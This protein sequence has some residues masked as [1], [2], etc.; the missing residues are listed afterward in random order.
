MLLYWTLANLACIKQSSQ[1][2]NFL[3]PCL[4]SGAGGD[5]M[6]GR[7]WSWRGLATALPANSLTDSGLVYSHVSHKLRHH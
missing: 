2:G 6:W 1:F 7:E 3:L 5:H 4:F